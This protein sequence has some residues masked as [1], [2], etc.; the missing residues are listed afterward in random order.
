MIGKEE[1]D[2]FDVRASKYY[3]EAMKNISEEDKRELELH[4]ESFRKEYEANPKENVE[5][6][7]AIRR[8]VWFMSKG[9]GI[10]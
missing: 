4:K 1:L 10:F 6:E 3:D 9:L 5:P 8:H 2:E 7:I